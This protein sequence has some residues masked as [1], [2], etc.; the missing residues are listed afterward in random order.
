MMNYYCYHV[1]AL[2]VNLKKNSVPTISHDRSDPIKRINRKFIQ[3]FTTL[4]CKI[5]LTR[6][7]LSNKLSKIISIKIYLDESHK[8][9]ATQ[10]FDFQNIDVKSILQILKVVGIY[11]NFGVFFFK[12][13]Y[14]DPVKKAEVYV[15]V[16]KLGAAKLFEDE[17]GVSELD[18]EESEP[19]SEPILACLTCCFCSE[20]FIT[21]WKVKLGSVGR[22]AS[23]N[24]ITDCLELSRLWPRPK[25][26]QMRCVNILLILMH[27]L[28][29][30]LDEIEQVALH[31]EHK[32][33]IARLGAASF[34]LCG[35]TADRGAPEAAS[36]LF[37]ILNK[38]SFK[39]RT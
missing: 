24:T 7:I 31:I 34:E 25:Y 32:K 18:E 12:I 15:T 23:L 28:L 1:M 20:V 39:I 16:T 2:A 9:S 33:A 22:S 17:L 38:G 37:N 3:I 26:S 36:A 6:I 27:C 4:R 5:K 14:N 8:S 11:R 19:D 10:D 30:V 35:S 21:A 13:L 29:L